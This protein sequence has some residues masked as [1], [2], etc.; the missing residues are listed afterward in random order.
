MIQNTKNTPTHPKT[1]DPATHVHASSG[2]PT[3]ESGLLGRSNKESNG[4]Q[5]ALR[6]E[7]NDHHRTVLVRRFYA[8]LVGVLGGPYVFFKPQE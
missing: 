8:K 5:F 1:N 6:R 2:S 7:V 3:S 4:S